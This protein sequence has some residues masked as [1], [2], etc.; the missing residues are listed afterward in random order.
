[1]FFTCLFLGKCPKVIEEAKP[2]NTVT[3]DISLGS[4][5]YL[6]EFSC[7]QN[8]QLYVLT[9]PCNEKWALFVHRILR[10]HVFHE[11]FSSKPT[12]YIPIDYSCYF[13]R[14]SETI[15]T[16]KGTCL[17]YHEGYEIPMSLVYE[18]LS[19]IFLRYLPHSWTLHLECT[20]SMLHATG[21]WYTWC[22][23]AISITRISCFS[24]CWIRE[25][26]YLVWLVLSVSETVV[27]L[28]SILLG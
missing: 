24:K 4:S 12:L 19:A 1:M 16:C 21:F 18:L 28:R 7:T 25:R 23:A 10:I 14:A 17:T 13:V 26:Y 3:R 22:N 20:H 2:H 6:C 27:K 15:S 11:R 5:V 9:P 8:Q